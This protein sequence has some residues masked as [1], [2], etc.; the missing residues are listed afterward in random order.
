MNFL[1]R[2][3]APLAVL[4]IIGGL[5]LA[6]LLRAQSATQDLTLV[7]GWNAVWLAVEP[8]YS[9]DHP[10]AGEA[11]APEDVF[12]DL[13]IVAIATPK[14]LAGLAEFFGHDPGMISTF[15]EDE[16]QQWKRTD[17]SNSNNLPM[18]F[19]NRPY[20]IRTSGPVT[21]TL[22]GKARFFHPSLDP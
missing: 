13:A 12:T 17:P 6:P 4:P 18:I 7:S 16:W 20:L 10:Q 14:P 5:L 11:M 8:I 21:L 2:L 15:N 9:E 19:S 22:T 1:K 3:L